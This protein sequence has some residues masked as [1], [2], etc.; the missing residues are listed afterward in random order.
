MNV[1]RQQNLVVH[2]KE[3]GYVYFHDINQFRYEWCAPTDFIYMKIVM[4]LV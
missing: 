4:K 3:E 2:L 1:I